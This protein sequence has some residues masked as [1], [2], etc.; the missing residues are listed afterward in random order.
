MRRASDGDG[1]GDVEESMG[2][3]STP[4]VATVRVRPM[5]TESDADSS[6]SPS[7]ATSALATRTPAL[8]W[9][10]LFASLLAISCAG[11]LLRT[12]ADTP[13]LLKGFWRSDN[14]RDSM[15]PQFCH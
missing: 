12:L 8:Y 3:R 15:V 9:C 4:T 2:V 6:Q 1:D 13:P 5:E 11:T 14:Q 7:G 10:I